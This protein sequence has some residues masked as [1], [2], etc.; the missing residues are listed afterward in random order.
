MAVAA[1]FDLDR[2]LIAGSSAEVFGAKLAEV[3]IATPAVPGQFLLFKVYEKL[4]EDPFTMRLA[5]GVAR[6]FAG[7][8]VVDVEA[9]AR[10]SAELLIGRVLP[11]ARAEI[12]RHRREGVLLVLATTSPLDLVSPLADALGFDAVI[13]TRYRS[14]HGV[15][16]GTLEGECVWGAEKARAVAA[17]S[18]ANAID[19]GA[20]WAYSD[21]WYDLPLLDL[22]GHPVAVNPD[23]RLQA[24]AAARGWTVRDFD[25]PTG[26]MG[27]AGL[28]GQELL[29]PL[30][31][32]RLSAFAD[33]ALHGAENL[34]KEGPV[35]V[36]ANHR[37]YFDPFALAY[38]AAARDRPL[39]FLAKKEVLDVPVLGVLVGALGTI[40]VDRGSGSTEPLDAAARALDGGE[41]VVILP[42]GT[43]PR[44]EDF[45]RAKLRGHSGVARLAQRTGAPIVPV[46][47]WGTEL[48]W[49]RNRRLP[50]LGSI[51]QR[52]QVTVRVGAPMEVDIDE[53]P[54]R[55]TDAVM[56]AIRSLLPEQAQTDRTPTD[57][58]LAATMADG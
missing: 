25:R 3:G 26:V 13:S 47:L 9:A 55:A 30:F 39:R 52:P 35:I 15:Y 29:F 46:G 41:A 34:P 44:G 19:L 33:I 20:S 22:V 48:V 54:R 56:T 45:F 7:R 18:G 31:D 23:V 32:R 37:S 53:R 2:T 8:R 36:A 38:L 6:S 17:W 10:S 58:E 12:D 40:P 50:R 11:H 14:I 21:S 4:G 28:E 1:F 57:E 42:Q 27:L 16:D 43:I 5:R 24:A 51:A 49:P